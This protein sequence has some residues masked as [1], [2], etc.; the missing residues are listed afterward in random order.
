MEREPQKTA[1][2][3]ASK[4]LVALVLIAAPG[5]V[6]IL[7]SSRITVARGAYAGRPPAYLPRRPIDTGGFSYY[8]AHLPPWKPDASLQEISKICERLGYRDIEEIDR[9]LSDRGKTGA[10]RFTLEVT[11]AILLNYEGEPNRAYEEVAP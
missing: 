2:R 10:Q 1:Y 7:N 8:L 6:V 4:L 5:I 9:S 3:F 11:K